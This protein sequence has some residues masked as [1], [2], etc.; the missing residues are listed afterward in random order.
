L[1]VHYLKKNALFVEV[2]VV[3][4]LRMEDFIETL[5]IIYFTFVKLA[6]DVYEK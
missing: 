5:L 2:G 1:N 3:R 6:C 4:A